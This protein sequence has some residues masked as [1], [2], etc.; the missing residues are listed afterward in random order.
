MKYPYLGHIENDKE[1][2]VI[3]FLKENYGMVV[4]SNVSDENLSFGT[5]SNFNEKDF[6]LLPKDRCVRL[7]N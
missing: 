6:E 2:L 5:L 3:L 1:N 7:S 4:M